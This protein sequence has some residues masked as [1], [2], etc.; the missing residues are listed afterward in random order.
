MGYKINYKIWGDFM[1]VELSG[2]YPLEKFKE[3]DA[4][5]DSVVDSNDINRLLVDLRKFKGRFGVFDGLN[6]IEDF[7]KESK[8]LQFAV[9]D[10]PENKSNNEFFENASYN[11]GYKIMFF[12]D[13]KDALKWLKIANDTKPEKELVREF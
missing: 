1:K 8:L 13:I 3:V 12:Y 6:H 10:L 7:R 4:D 2:E 11:R 5:I 9:L